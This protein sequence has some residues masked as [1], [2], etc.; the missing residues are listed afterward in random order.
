MTTTKPVELDLRLFISCW[1]VI[2]VT[3]V[4]TAAGL[5]EGTELP[6]HWNLSFK[7]DRYASH[8][9]AL[10]MLPTVAAVIAILMK[11]VPRLEPRKD[12]LQRSMIAY[13]GVFWGVQLFLLVLQLYMVSYAWDWGLEMPVFTGICLSILFLTIGNFLGKTRSTYLFGIRTPWTL[14]SERVWRKTHQLGGRLIF[15]L[16]VLQLLSTPWASSVTLVS[17]LVLLI[18]ILLAMTWYSYR[19]WQS[20]KNS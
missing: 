11:V 19:L 12:N 16:G 1:A 6:I 20:E 3:S 5:P 9:F 7:P 13:T 2:F 14:S 8:W 18:S 10:L 15:G 17:S 4:Y